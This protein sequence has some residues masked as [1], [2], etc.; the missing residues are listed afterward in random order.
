MK[1]KI[2]IFIILLTIN[3]NILNASTGSLKSASIVECDGVLYGTHGNDNHY[4]EAEETTNGKYKAKGDS[5]GRDWTC[6]GNLKN[7][8]DDIILEKVNAKFE[9]CIDG[10]TAVFNINGESTKF[11]FLAIDTPETVHPTKGEEAYGKNASEY[12]CNKIKQA[13]II[14][15]EYENEKLDKYGRNLGWIW[16]D[17]SLLQKELIENGYAEV[18][19]IYGNYKYTNNLCETQKI[20]IEN[21][22]G[23]W[24]DGK[25]KE[26]YCSTLRET[27]LTNKKV[28]I[29]DTNSEKEN[30]NTK[31][32][33]L[34]TTL[35]A[36]FAM[37]IVVLKALKK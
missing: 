33:T 9:K 18:A 2:F 32:Y 8:K 31:S 12:T 29:T 24:Q 10:D 19:Y 36:A 37:I 3:F 15:I 26:G 14:E 30:K 7:P 34:E 21:Q 6:K 27:P 17:G 1:K 13:K 11:R 23:I 20:S 5:L 28:A 35:I 4:H 16:I 22:R 25:R